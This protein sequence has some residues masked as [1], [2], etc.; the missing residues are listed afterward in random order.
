VEIPTPGRTVRA[1][2][3]G[4][5]EEDAS[6]R[7]LGRHPELGYRGIDVLKIPHHGARNGGTA[8]FGT[9]RP[10]LAL[11]S[12]GQGNDYGHPHP[13]VVAGLRKLAIFTARTDRLGTFTVSIPGGAL[14]VRSLD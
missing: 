4:D 1:L 3:T 6:R 7:L 14:E 9:L 10:R 11:L 8:I 2:F 12:S 5:I 13:E